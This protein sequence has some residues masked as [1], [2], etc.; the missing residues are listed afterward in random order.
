MALEKKENAWGS[1]VHRSKCYEREE[2]C[3]ILVSEYNS[4]H[5]TQENPD[6][7]NYLENKKENLLKETDEEEFCNVNDTLNNF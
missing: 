1:K 7:E 3:G 4:N 6:A 5:Y 2:M